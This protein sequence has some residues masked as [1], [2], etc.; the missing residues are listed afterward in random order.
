MATST[1]ITS[2]PLSA[3]PEELNSRLA[4]VATPFVTFLGEGSR[5][6]PGHMERIEA[7]L[8]QRPDTAVLVFD[9]VER[10][11]EGW[12]T[13]CSPN[14]DSLL[15]DHLTGR[16][17]RPENVVLSVDLVRGIGPLDESL[18]DAAMTDYL[19]R[20]LLSSPSTRKL[21]G[22][23][24]L[25]VAPADPVHSPLSP[26]SLSTALDGWAA[27]A[28]SSELAAA[29]TTLINIGRMVVAG[30]MIKQGDKKAGTRLSDRV[31]ESV[32]RAGARIKLGFVRDTEALFG[33]G[34]RTLGLLLFRS[35]HRHREVRVGSVL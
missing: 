17:V 35:G 6:L 21:T 29:L 13:L 28:R 11:E 18:G 24:T 22:E 31:L 27:A 30:Q 1:L 12:T 16:W 3:T 34:G 8:T 23:P 9:T 2:I 20:A 32:D 10:D 7:E 4:A 5:M 15:A 19:G 14:I 25:I 33:R 26:L